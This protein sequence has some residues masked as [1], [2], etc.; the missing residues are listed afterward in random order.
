MSQPAPDRSP[1]AQLLVGIFDALEGDGIRYCVLRGYADLPQATRNDVDL[2]IDPAALDRVHEHVARVARDAGWLWAGRDD[3]SGVSRVKLFHP[4]HPGGMLPLDLCVEHSVWGMRY[5]D[6][7]FVLD[8]ELR[9]EGIRVARPGCEAAV[10]L[11]KGLLR[12]GTVK[13]RASHRD[14]LQTCTRED[15]QSFAACAAPLVG[16]ALCGELLDACQRAD[17]EAA[18]ARAPALRRALARRSGP[19][20]V[21]SKALRAALRT[22][23]ARFS[24]RGGQEFRGGLFICLLGPDGSGKTTLSRALEARIGGL[25][26]ETEQFHSVSGVFPRLRGLKRIFYGLQGREVPESPL[27]G[28]AMP[29]VVAKPSPAWRAT[30]YILYYGVEY[31]LYRFTVGSKVRRNHLVIFDRYFYDYYLMRVHMNAPRWLLDLFS[32]WIAQP[33]V[34]FVMLADPEAIYRRKPELTPEEIERQQTILKGLQLPRSAQIDTSI[35]V[36]R[37]VDEALDVIVPL[38]GG[39]VVRSEPGTGSSAS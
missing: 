14:R 12:H 31:M 19:L 9:H 23:M 18:I 10:S 8:T 29:G 5:A 26:A 34:L 32:R 25:F 13:A 16:E 21:L 3:Q 6:P 4:E 17:W 38:L 30:I 7:E 22:R 35:S 28:V 36:E 37:T 39:P 24:R 33:D 15:P 20:R 27:K 1:L 2:A 11:L